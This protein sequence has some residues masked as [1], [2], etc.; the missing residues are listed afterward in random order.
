MAGGQPAVQPEVQ[1]AKKKGRGKGRPFPEG[2]SPNPGG[3]P[4]VEEP[5]PLGGAVSA[6]RMQRVLGQGKAADVGPTEKVLRRWLEKDTKGYLD[7]IDKKAKAEAEDA[8]D[9]AEL[10][11][12]RAENAE[13]KGMVEADDYG[14][15]PGTD[16][17]MAKIED[18]ERL[19]KEA[20]DATP[21]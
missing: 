14:D 15:D 7:A 3:V 20:S 2:E 18:V 10:E 11:R 9:R 19:L 1:P 4:K 12:L 13:L 6:A 8:A 21:A 16:R 17:L 5:D